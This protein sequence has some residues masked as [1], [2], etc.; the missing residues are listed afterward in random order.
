MFGET[1]RYILVHRERTRNAAARSFCWQHTRLLLKAQTSSAETAK[2]TQKQR[3][4]QGCV[5]CVWVCVCADVCCL[6]FHVFS[7]ESSRNTHTEHPYEMYP[8]CFHAKSSQISVLLV[9]SSV[10]IYVAAYH[11][12]TPVVVGAMAA[13]VGEGEARRLL[14]PGFFI[15]FVS[16]SISICPAACSS[17]LCDC[18]RDA[19][20]PDQPTPSISKESE[21]GDRE[22]TASTNTHTPH[23][24]VSIYVACVT[25]P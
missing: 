11:M 20:R 18:A 15:D 24:R 7:M 10:A 13:A 17:F 14:L 22:A 23:E 1:D 21:K 16:I 19:G 5:R 3:V 2:Y 9:G 25:Q 4:R 12:I 6:F 8:P